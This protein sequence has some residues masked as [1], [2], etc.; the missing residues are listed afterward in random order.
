[1]S[2][3]ITINGV[4]P[5]KEQ[6]KKGKTDPSSLSAQSKALYDR[7]IA[8]RK[9]EADATEALRQQIAKDWSGKLP[10]NLDVFVGFR[11][12]LCVL[13]VD[14]RTPSNA[15]ASFYDDMI[16]AVSAGAAGAKA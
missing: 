14:K 13:A 5:S 9:A 7:V 1:M 4:E 8:A 11:F 16:R 3:K 6:W 10:K 12:G 2:S 15:G